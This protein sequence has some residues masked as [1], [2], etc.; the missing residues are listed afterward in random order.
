MK[1]VKEEKILVVKYA[2]EVMDKKAKLVR[3]LNN[4]IWGREMQLLGEYSKLGE[5]EKSSLVEL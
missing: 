4:E 1:V 2:W 5:G 3:S